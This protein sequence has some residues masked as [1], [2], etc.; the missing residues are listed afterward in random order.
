MDLFEVSGDTRWL[1]EAIGLDDV[2]QKHYED[3]EKGGFFLT[4]DDHQKLLAREKPGYDGAEPSGNSVEALNLLRLD[5]FTGANRSYARRAEQTLAAFRRTLT[6]NPS[7]LSEMLAALDFRY[8]SP[9]E[10]VIVAHLSREQAEPFLERLRTTYLPNRTVAVVTEGEDQAAQ[11]QLVPTVRSKIA[12]EGKTT[13]YVCAKKTC[14]L[15]TTDPDVFARQIRKV[16][17]L[18]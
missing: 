16:Q 3:T 10:I 2:L 8:D 4:S 17:P 13:A 12:R 18:R 14:E 15:P 5:A 9:K 1:R 6:E 11:G 7:A